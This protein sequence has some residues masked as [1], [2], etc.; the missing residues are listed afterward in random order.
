[1]LGTLVEG[2]HLNQLVLVCDQGTCYWHQQL[3]FL[4]IRKSKI[5]FLF[6]VMNMT[7]ISKMLYNQYQNLYIAPTVEEYWKA[8]KEEEWK[9]RDGKDVIL[10]S[11]G[12]N[13]SPGHCAQY[14]TY[15]FADMESKTILNV[16]IVDVRE[17]E[18]KKST[19]MERLG[20]ERGLDELL[21]STMSIQE[22]VTDGHLG[23]SALMSK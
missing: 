12:R 20:F 7:Y 1:M 22:L 16:N 18:G 23:I 10:S 9:G 11:D 3:H 8:M 6:K 15:S 13:D 4:A 21:T 5:G 19:N 2:G 17:V 14:L